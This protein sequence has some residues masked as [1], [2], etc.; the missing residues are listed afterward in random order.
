[1]R[2]S[3]RPMRRRLWMIIRRAPPARVMLWDMRRFRTARMR[4]LRL[5]LGLALIVSS[6]IIGAR[7]LSS[8]DDRVQVWQTTRDLHEGAVPADLIPVWVSRDVARDTYAIAT[9]PVTGTLRWP[10]TAG[11]L[12]PVSSLIWETDP[13]LDLRAVAVPVD[14]RRLPDLQPGQRVDVWTTDT[15][16]RTPPR[17]VLS[18]VLVSAVSA[19]ASGIASDLTVKL[20]VPTRNVGDVVAASRAGVVDLATVPVPGTSS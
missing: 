2:G 15:Q 1:M 9:Q 6:M 12:V 11:Q 5:W 13:V 10:L 7:I 18:N 17:L 4:D 19:D 8:G 20:Q 16:E 3:A 14:S